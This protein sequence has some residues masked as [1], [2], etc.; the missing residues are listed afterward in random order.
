MRVEHVW[1]QNTKERE[2]WTL[3][4]KK[5]KNAIG[6]EILEL[7]DLI[8]KHTYT[9]P[10]SE[11]RQTIQRSRSLHMCYV[12]MR[13]VVGW[14]WIALF[15]ILCTAT[16]VTFP[17]EQPRALPPTSSRR[18]CM[19]MCPVNPHLNDSS[20]CTSLCDGRLFTPAFEWNHSEQADTFSHSQ[21]TFSAN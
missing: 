13:K 21:M 3:L 7:W 11:F 15:F 6:E 18:E 20:H 8:K 2:P 17:C 4:S 10:T 12:R 16:S 9:F 1:Q 14:L 19:K 5:K